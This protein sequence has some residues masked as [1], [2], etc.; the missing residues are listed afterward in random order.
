MQSSARIFT[1]LLVAV[2]AV[3]FGL[4]NGAAFAGDGRTALQLADGRGVRHCHNTPRRVYCHTREVLPISLPPNST[5][6]T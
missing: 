5:V 3:P 4:Q 6:R 2:T 1:A